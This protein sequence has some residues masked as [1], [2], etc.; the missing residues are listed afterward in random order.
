MASTWGAAPAFLAPAPTGV[1]PFLL[2]GGGAD[3]TAGHNA[4]SLQGPGPPPFL[5]DGVVDLAGGY[6][7]NAQAAATGQGS[8]ASGPDIFTRG[9]V[10]LGA[11]YHGP[12]LTADFNYALTDYYYAH[13]T[14]LNQLQNQFNLATTAQLVPNHLSFNLNAFATPATLSRVGPISATQV[15]PSNANSSSFFGYIAEPVLETQLGEYATSQTSLTE[16]QLFTSQSSSPFSF[17]QP[18]PLNTGPFAPPG[19]STVTSAVEHMASTPFFGRFAWELN[20]SFTNTQQTGQSVQQKQATADL[21][22]A[23]DRWV[24]VLGTV[25]YNQFTTSVPLTQS[26]SGPIALGG[27]HLSYGHTFSLIAKAGT[28]NNFP[29]Y[30]GSLKWDVTPRFDIVGSLTDAV[31]TTPGQILSNLSTLAVAP[32]GAFFNTQTICQLIPAQPQSPQLP[33]VSPVPQL[34]LPLNNAINR[35]QNA[36]L[37]FVHHDQRTTYTLSFFRTAQDQLS[38]T[39]GTIQANTSLYGASYNV[40]HQL[41]HNL[42]GYAGVSYS[43]ASEFGGQDRIVT[44]TAGLNYNLA[45]HLDTYLTVSYLQRQSSGQIVPNVLFIPNGTNVPFVTSG[46]LTDLVTMIGIRRTFGH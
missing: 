45:K 26:L 28:Q 46:N 23:L 31:T 12:R 41:R 36:Q 9:I 2:P 18:S 35:T 15:L 7:T 42:S 19:N 34:C 11:H 29:T 38:V 1:L 40:T 3:L 22:Y 30:Q 27:V 21:S 32:G 24:A 14:S 6:T 39:P 8:S 33:I 17:S 20:G 43:V 44:A 25:G 5:L 16:S 4:G 37:A 10:G 13:F